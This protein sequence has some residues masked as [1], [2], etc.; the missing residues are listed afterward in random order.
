MMSPL[1]Y[2]FLM[3]MKTKQPDPDAMSKVEPSSGEI[4]D[5]KNIV[6]AKNGS[7]EMRTILMEPRNAM[8]EKLE[9]PL[10]ITSQWEPMFKIGAPIT[11]K[12]D[13]SGQIYTAKVARIETTRD[14]SGETIQVIAELDKGEAALQPGLTAT[15]TMITAA[16]PLTNN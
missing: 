11:V 4:V 1:D 5:S 6:V 12:M 14:D 13:Q 16:R 15:A 8:S 3:M 7:L 2:L 10:R 9:A